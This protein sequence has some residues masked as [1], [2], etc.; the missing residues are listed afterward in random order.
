MQEFSRATPPEVGALL[1]LGPASGN[2]DID[3]KTGRMD[4][5]RL[6]VGPAPASLLAFVLLFPL[7]FWL[8]PRLGRQPG[9]GVSGTSAGTDT[10][11]V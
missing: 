3:I 1:I 11:N 10:R 7:S 5:L 4:T 2:V 6:T 9:D 8:Y